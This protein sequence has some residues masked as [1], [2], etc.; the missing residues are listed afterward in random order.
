M[1]LRRA[2]AEARLSITRELP[3]PPEV[4]FDAWLDPAGVGSWLCPFSISHTDALI[5]ARVGGRFVLVMHEPGCAYEHTG[6]YLAIDR[7]RRLQFTWVSKGT[8]MTASL[9]TLTLA[10]RGEGTL[11]ELVHERLPHDRAATG[12]EAGWRSILDKLTEHLSR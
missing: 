11:L 2:A 9:V 10:P 4:V 1:T 3:P 5:D 6:E 12:H 8:E 7:P